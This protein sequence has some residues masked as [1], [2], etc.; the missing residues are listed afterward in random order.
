MHA[1]SP[2]QQ[3]PAL[4]AGRVALGGARAAPAE[5][6]VRAVAATGVARRGCSAARRAGSRPSRPSTT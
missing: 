1:R 5:T 4:S 6:P 2:T 3:A